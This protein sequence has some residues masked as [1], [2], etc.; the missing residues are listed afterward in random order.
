[1]EH[2][3]SS[4][5]AASTPG[6][7]G[8]SRLPPWEVTDIPRVPHMS[9]SASPLSGAE[10]RALSSFWTTTTTPAQPPNSNMDQRFPDSAFSSPSPPSR[11]ETGSWSERKQSLTGSTRALSPQRSEHRHMNPA[12]DQVHG[13]GPPNGRQHVVAL[14]GT[15][16][17]RSTLEQPQSTSSK[18]ISNK[19]QHKKGSK[20]PKESAPIGHRFTSAVKELFRKEPV[21]DRQFERI[22]ERH[23]SED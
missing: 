3:I 9:S 17:S 13:D 15:M 1:M 7:S 14:P 12:Y 22:G 20:G 11:A 16:S 10:M 4:A 5:S 19:R 23:W 6:N 2:D 18:K 8:A 21:D